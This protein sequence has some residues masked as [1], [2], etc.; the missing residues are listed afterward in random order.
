MVTEGEIPNK[1]V[2]R[3]FYSLTGWP[4]VK[5]SKESGE[6][7]GVSLDLCCHGGTR[8]AINGFCSLVGL[9]CVTA[10]VQW[11]EFGE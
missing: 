3:V 2:R 5:Y 1:I 6:I 11:R 8:H 7:M 10:V 4:I 9:I